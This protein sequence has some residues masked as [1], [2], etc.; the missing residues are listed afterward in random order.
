MSFL[1]GE[2]RRI[3]LRDFMIRIKQ[4]LHKAR[5]KELSHYKRKFNDKVATFNKVF[6]LDPYFKN[7]IGNKKKVRIA[8]LGCGLLSTT[9]S[10]WPGVEVELHPSDFLAEK[11][12]RLFERSGVKRVIPIEKQDMEALTYEDESFDI[13]NCINA[14]DHAV[15][16][17]IALLEML[18]IV[19]PGGWIYLRHRVDTGLVQKY[20]GLH[21]WNIKLIVND[22][23]IYNERE[24][25]W[26]SEMIPG[27][28]SKRI[29]SKG[30]PEHGLIVSTY[31]KI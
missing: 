21:Q 25:F 28:K 23:K 12:D 20:N 8:D 16:P 13:V 22:C 30:F 17:D 2:G 24:W 26:M 6:E 3:C 31:Q 18:R 5:L 19:R 9:G 10:T 15:N 11:Y 29:E 1:I 4:D 7:L 14:L 27:I